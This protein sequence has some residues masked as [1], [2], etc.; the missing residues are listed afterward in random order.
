MLALVGVLTA[1]AFM[2]WQPLP[3]PRPGLTQD[4]YDRIEV[5]MTLPEVEALLGRTHSH[6]YIGPIPQNWDAG[7]HVWLSAEK[8]HAVSVMMD[9][10]GKL[11]SKSSKCFR[12]REND[13]I[14]RLLRWCKRQWRLWFP[15]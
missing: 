8:G 14:P 10:T 12:D 7:E 4:N 11:Q 6:L 5:G 1:G 9:Q 13:P 15:G 3:P 2:P